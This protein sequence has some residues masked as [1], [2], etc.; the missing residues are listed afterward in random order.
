MFCYVEQ[1]HLSLK[2][3]FIGFNIQQDNNIQQEQKEIYLP[4]FSDYNISNNN[5]FIHLVENEVTLLEGAYPAVWI[6]KTGTLKERLKEMIETIKRIRTKIMNGYQPAKLGGP[7]HVIDGVDVDH[8]RDISV[9]GDVIPV[10]L[11][12]IVHPG[13]S[14]EYPLN[15]LSDKTNLLIQEYYQWIGE[16]TLC[17]WINSGVTNMRYH[18]VHESKCTPNRSKSFVP[19]SM[20]L[21]TLNA[22]PAN[23]IVFPTFPSFYYTDIPKHV[24]Y[25]LIATNAVFTYYGDLIAGKTKYVPYTCWRDLSPE[26]D[27]NFEKAPLYEEVYSIAERWGD[28]FYHLNIEDLPRIAPFLIWLRENPQ[29]KIHIFGDGKHRY[30][31]ISQ[32]ME[33]LQISKERLVIGPLRARFAY[34]PET[35]YCGFNHVTNTQLLSEEY[36]YVIHNNF[37]QKKRDSIVLIKRS[38]ARR[39][40][41][42]SEI[43]TMLQRIAK[44]Y[45]LTFEHF[46][47]THLPSVKDTMEMFNRAVMVV[48]PH[49]A[50]LSN[51][52]FSEP[53]TFVIEGVCNRPHVNLCFQR[54]AYTLGHHYH[55]IQSNRGC[56]SYIE[57]NA[58]DIEN[59]VLTYIK[60]AV[61]LKVS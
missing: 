16:P 34:M 9:S 50:G 22:R 28:G 54:L 38:A 46:V 1:L 51:I 5:S 45:N 48:G 36:R 17:K 47:D 12:W 2:F 55:G 6:K 44:D 18:V 4:K 52:I 21:I 10:F 49:G 33:Y 23:K 57:I 20:H 7:L 27:P 53:G 59:I 8:L 24:V 35:T 13:G 42:H 58:S 40:S 32:I 37:K 56:E 25:M 31:Y 15:T 30:K 29:I 39:F 61:K 11:P 60:H 3:S 41:K 43:Q 14:K 26:Y 19:Q